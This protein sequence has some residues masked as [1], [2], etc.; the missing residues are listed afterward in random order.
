M[1]INEQANHPPALTVVHFIAERAEVE[2]ESSD[3]EHGQHHDK[4]GR[5]QDDGE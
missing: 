3:G 5:H 4:G 1:P 2:R